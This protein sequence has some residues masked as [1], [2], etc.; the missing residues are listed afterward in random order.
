MRFQ[1]V[2]TTIQQDP[3]VRFTRDGWNDRTRC[4]FGEAPMQVTI[5]E[6]EGPVMEALCRENGGSVLVLGTICGCWKGHIQPGVS[7]QHDDLMADDWEM[8]E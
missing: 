2:L 6:A 5:D 4:I 1:D 7:L 8:V 3:T